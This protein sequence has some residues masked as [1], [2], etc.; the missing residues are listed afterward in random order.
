MS[1]GIASS[2]MIIQSRTGKDPGEAALRTQSSAMPGG[3]DPVN[4][5][6][7][8]NVA[9]LM[10]NNGVPSA[11]M[12]SGQSVADLQAATAGGNPALIHVNNPTPP[13]GGHFMVADGVTTDSSGTRQVQV[14]DPWP[15]GSGTQSTMSEQQLQQRGYSG[16]AVTTN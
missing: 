4:G 3:Y 14:R 9:Q 13:G 5:T 16:W 10:R 12:R 11:T 15:P 8:D 7:M 2:R 6:R 1:C